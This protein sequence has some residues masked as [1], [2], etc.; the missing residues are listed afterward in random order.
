[1]ADIIL[2]LSELNKLFYDLTVA[3][4]SAGTQ[5]RISWATGGAPAFEIDENLA[6][7]KVYDVPLGVP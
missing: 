4:V 5:V 6:F 1:M 7:I 2:S 3:M